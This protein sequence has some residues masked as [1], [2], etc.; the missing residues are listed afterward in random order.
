MKTRR[1][2]GWERGCALH[3]R[4]SSGEAIR[5]RSLQHADDN[6]MKLYRS[7]AQQSWWLHLKIRVCLTGKKVRRY[8]LRILRVLLRRR[9]V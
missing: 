6:K 9:S 7:K 3:L 5:R 4:E 2:V 1:F 8:V